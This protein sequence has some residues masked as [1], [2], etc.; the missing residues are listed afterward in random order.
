M[1]DD[2]PSQA[3]FDLATTPVHLGRRGSA[4][5][6]ADFSW[7]ADGIA[8]HEQRFASD[9]TEARLVL[10]EDLTSTWDVWER[11][12]AG[13]ELVVAMTGRYE[14][15]QDLDGR[16]RRVVLGPGQATINPPGIWHTLDVIDPGQGLF[17]TAGVGTEHRP[18]TPAG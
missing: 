12:P 8:A 1:D 15:L 5:A 9:G 16:Q 10:L 18:R 7:S 6:L 2:A 17:V 4:V 14:L 13:A 3:S 11:H